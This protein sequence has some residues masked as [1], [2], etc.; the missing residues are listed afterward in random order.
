MNDPIVAFIYIISFGEY[1]KIGKTCQRLSDKQINR[2]QQYTGVFRISLLIYVDPDVLDDLE[3]RILCDLNKT[4]KLAKG[5]EYFYGDEAT[6]RTIVANHCLCL[7]LPPLDPNLP[8]DHLKCQHC[9]KMLCT[10]ASLT[11]HQNKCGLLREESNSISKDKNI[12]VV[13]YEASKLLSDITIQSFEALQQINKATYFIKQTIK[14]FYFF[15]LCIQQIILPGEHVW[16]FDLFLKYTT[17]PLINSHIHHIII[18]C[19]FQIP[20]T[21]SNLKRVYNMLK[22]MKL[23]CEILQLDNSFDTGNV[24]KDQQLLE[25]KNFYLDNA[26]DLNQIFLIHFKAKDF[27]LRQSITVINTIFKAWNGFSIHVISSKNYK[28][29]N[30]PNTDYV[31]KLVN[32]SIVGDYAQHIILH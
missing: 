17:C 30:T 16:E 8:F 22:Y 6:I 32:N 3:T 7:P 2:F 13:Q 15:K 11:R 26:T 27:K 1:V 14:A 23:I 20:P 28:S 19:G 4:F 29:R 31:C 25:F 12:T 5:R 21:L 10:A 18:E 9:D 24:I